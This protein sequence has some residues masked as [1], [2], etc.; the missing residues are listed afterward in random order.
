MYWIED[1][2][3]WVED[4][5]DVTLMSQNPR[6]LNCTVVMSIELHLGNRSGCYALKKSGAP[7]TVPQASRESGCT[8]FKAMHITVAPRIS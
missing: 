8:T 3:Y 2:I 5:F 6:V 1:V 7:H 4:V